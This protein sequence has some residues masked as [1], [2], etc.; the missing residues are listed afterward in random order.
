MPCLCHCSVA[1]DGSFAFDNVWPGAYSVSVSNKEDSV[2][3]GGN[4]P[5]GS[6]P[7]DGAARKEVSSVEH[8]TPHLYITCAT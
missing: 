5:M 3:W 2:C 7:N 4:V 8:H 6:D 1:K